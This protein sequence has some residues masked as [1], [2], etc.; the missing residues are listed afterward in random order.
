MDL[1]CLRIHYYN[2]FIF[3][4]ITALVEEKLGCLAGFNL[5]KERDHITSEGIIS[6]GLSNKTEISIWT[7]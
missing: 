5:S 7:F 1:L 2:Y 6:N 4:F 3:F